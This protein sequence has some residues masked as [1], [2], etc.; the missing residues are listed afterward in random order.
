MARIYDSI[1]DTIGN[2]PLVR[3][4]KVTDGAQATVLAK[5]ESFNPAG[6]V[7]D[8]IGLAM[9]ADAEEKGILKPE[10]VIVEPT[11]GNTG[12]AL[13]FVAAAGHHVPG[14]P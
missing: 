12:I 9:I 3:L 14:A 2:T 11:S 5:V 1:V 7:K 13:A 6:S 4:N 10:T 8:R